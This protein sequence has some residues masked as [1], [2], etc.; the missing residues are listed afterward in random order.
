MSIG[1]FTTGTVDKELTAIPALS[2]LKSLFS[3]VTLLSS[4]EGFVLLCLAS[5]GVYILNDLN[6]IESDRLHPTKCKRP[7]ASGQLDVKMARILRFLLLTSSLITAAF[8][9]ITFLVILVAYVVMNL[10]YSIGLKQAVI[11][12]V[13]IISAGFVLRAVAG[14]AAI[15]AEASTWLVLCTMMLT[16]VVEFGKRRNEL[17][18]PGD[19]AESHRQ[20]LALYSVPFLDPMISVSACAAVMTYA[21]YTLADETVNRFGTRNLV[22]TIPFVIYRVFRYMLLL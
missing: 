21:L 6:D 7:I 20:N 9:P 1:E 18:L 16:L 14:A 5:S 11:L 13:M 8:M 4:L 3:L 22:V 17:E 10:A 12:D 19:Q 15:N 2:F